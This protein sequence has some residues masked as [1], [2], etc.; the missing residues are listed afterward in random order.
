MDSLVAS[1]VSTSCTKYL[2]C[3]LKAGYWR[4]PC[5]P[6][7]KGGVWGLEMRPILVSAFG[8]AQCKKLGAQIQQSSWLDVNTSV[9]AGVSDLTPA[10]GEN[11]TPW[12][13]EEEA[14]IGG[15]WWPASSEDGWR[16]DRWTSRPWETVRD[17]ASK[18]SLDFSGTRT[19]TP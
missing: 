6:P 18:T 16:P 2:K 5:L 8:G 7:T 10:D 3:A 11:R 13:S 1:Q 17:V 12:G 4:I 9:E 15:G 19:R 14:T